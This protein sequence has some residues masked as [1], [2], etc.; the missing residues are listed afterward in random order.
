M[1]GKGGGLGGQFMVLLIQFCIM[2]QRKM[3]VYI[4]M[5]FLMNMMKI[6]EDVLSDD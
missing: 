3:M 6:I 2:Q 4:R 1:I 5:N